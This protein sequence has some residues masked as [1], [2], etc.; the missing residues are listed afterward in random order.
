MRIAIATVQVP[1]ISGGAEALAQGLFRACQAVGHEVE[2]V[3]MP[4]RFF[5]ETEVA[6]AMESWEAENFANINGYNPDIVAC[7]KFPTFYLSHQKKVV[8]LL[9]QHRSVYDLWDASDP[10]HSPEATAL[11][12][13]I[14]AKDNLHLARAERVYTI[15]ENVSKR[16][17]KHNGIASTA[18]YHPPPFAERLYW[19]RP[20]PYIFMPS[21]L[22]TLKR[23]TLLIRAMQHVKSPVAAFI[24]GEGGQRPTCERLIEELNLGRRVR[25]L[26]NLDDTAMLGYYASSLGVFFGPKDEDYGYVTLEAMLARKP[27]ITCTDS[28]G[29]LEFVRHNETGFVITPDPI[30]LAAAIDKL[31]DTPG[32]AADLGNA[33]FLR[34]HSMDISWEHAVCE[35][36]R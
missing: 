28:G 36:I 3:T 4:F 5:P 34:Y 11:R 22:E 35:L 29:P 13:R 31:H 23:Q 20:Q 21:R 16:M 27:V 9:H 33:G 32:L 17:R 2:I 6:R 18:L 26:G 1:F 25:L 12:E 8:W 24:A 19:A 7:L 30:E 10:N 15:A 14:I